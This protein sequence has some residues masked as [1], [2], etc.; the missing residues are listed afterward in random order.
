MRLIDADAL[1]EGRTE[2]DPVSIA[3][4]CAETIIVEETKEYKALCAQATAVSVEHL[5]EIIKLMEELKEQ[6]QLTS[7]LLQKR[8]G[9]NLW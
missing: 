6:Q 2:N 9:L 3:A 5:R 7:E 8:G 1:C 4:K